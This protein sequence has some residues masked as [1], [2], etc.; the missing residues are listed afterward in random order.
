MCSFLSPCCFG[1]CRSPCFIPWLCCQ[2]WSLL[3]SWRRARSRPRLAAGTSSFQHFITVP[4]VWLLHWFKAVPDRQSVE[5]K[6][7]WLGGHL[8][9]RNALFSLFCSPHLFFNFI[10]GCFFYCFLNILL[11]HLE[12]ERPFFH[13]TP[14][15]FGFRL[16]AFWDT[17]MFHLSSLEFTSP[18]RWRF[19]P[20]FL[21]SLICCQLLHFN[22]LILTQYSNG[23]TRWVLG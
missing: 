16:L 17:R 18:F 8:H 9:L 23:T 19:N 5:R 22:L 12:F 6:L 13:A 15:C 3:L 14:K 11:K 1:A 21:L 7:C 2:R 20:K 4:D 10:F